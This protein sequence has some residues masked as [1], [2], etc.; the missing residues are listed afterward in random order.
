MN[1][2]SLNVED[3]NEL[4]AT[5]PNGT[6][7]L[8]SE[9][10]LYPL[11]YLFVGGPAGSTLA[12]KMDALQ[13]SESLLLYLWKL[14]NA[15]SS[16]VSYSLECKRVEFTDQPP[17]SCQSPGTGSACNQNFNQRA[18]APQITWLQIR[19]RREIWDERGRPLDDSSFGSRV[20]LPP[21]GMFGRN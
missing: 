14:H 13:D 9:S 12:K 6:V 16:S 5:Y 4:S 1:W 8:A 15:V 2:T 21:S 20:V 3:G 7:A 10:G 17:W 18:I 19:S 11:E